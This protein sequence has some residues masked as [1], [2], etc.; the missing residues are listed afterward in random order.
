MQVSYKL[1]F[2]A[3]SSLLS[4]YSNQYGPDILLQLNV[5]YFF[6][7]IPVL[8]LQT[9]F[10]DRWG[11]AGGWGLA[12]RGG[13][14]SA[15]RTRDPFVPGVFP[16]NYTE[17]DIL[18]ITFVCTPASSSKH[19]FSLKP[20]GPF[21]SIPVRYPP[22]S[23]LPSL[24]LRMDRR[25]GLPGGALLRF[26]VGLGGLVALTHN[27]PQLTANSEKVRE[28]AWVSGWVLGRGGRCVVRTLG[29][30]PRTGKE[31]RQGWRVACQ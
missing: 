20:P 7:S 14:P 9:A 19:P 16:I 12:A 30:G 21:R 17:S 2:T 8:M 29:A 10:N 3:I 5:A 26:L 22:R 4:Q 31:E 27:F 23:C 1:A 24:L 15:T 18:P 28:D 25:L 6:P 11:Q 13:R